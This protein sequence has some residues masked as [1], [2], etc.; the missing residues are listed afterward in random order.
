M[1]VMHSASNVSIAKLDQLSQFSCMATDLR[2]VMAMLLPK[3]T[4]M[5]RFIR[6]GIEMG[7]VRLLDA[8]NQLRF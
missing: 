2:A 3:R 1:G 7:I 6:I 8:R 4:L 5:H